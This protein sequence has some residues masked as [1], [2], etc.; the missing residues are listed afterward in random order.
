MF[1]RLHNDI[2]VHH[3]FISCARKLCCELSLSL[4]DIMMR[5]LLL[6][7]VWLR[8]KKREDG[9]LCIPINEFGLTLRIVRRINFLK[10][11][12]IKI[13]NPKSFTV[14]DEGFSPPLYINSKTSSFDHCCSIS[15]LYSP[16]SCLQVF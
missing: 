7:C 11:I 16:L 8:E 1:G 5:L 3:S 9:K 10:Y 2:Y 15:M 6:G 13:I 4:K 14:A 12:L